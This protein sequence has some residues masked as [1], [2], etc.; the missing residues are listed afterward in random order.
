MSREQVPRRRSAVGLLRGRAVRLGRALVEVLFP[1]DGCAI[2]GDRLPGPAVWEP[3]GPRTPWEPAVCPVCL[4]DI[5]AGDAPG[6]SPVDSLSSP[7]AAFLDGAVT[8]GT[9]AGALEKAVLR[10]KNVPDRRLAR[11]LAHLLA[12]ALVEAGARGPWGAVVPVPLHPGRMRERGFNQ[13]ALLAE[14]IAGRLG[15]RALPALCERVRPTPLQTS[16]SRSERVVSVLGAFR[17]RDRDFFSGFPAAVLV[18]DD[19]L[20]TGATVGELARVLKAGGA[21]S[22]WCAAVARAR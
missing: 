8:A 12:E 20:T 11:V 16:L 22:V 6:P 14:E 9:Y 5:F 21:G 10:L 13:A 17:L 18:V 3:G 7:S 4:G 19:V 2:C 1:E 15:A